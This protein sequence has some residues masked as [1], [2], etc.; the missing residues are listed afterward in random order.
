MVN[1]VD[2]EYG[3]PEL[4]F[5]CYTEAFDNFDPAGGQVPGYLA[6]TGG[7][8]NNAA[9]DSHLSPRKDGYVRSRRPV[10]HASR[11]PRHS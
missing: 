10:R 4:A 1:V 7:G 5:H 9:S 8:V 2:S 3:G 11:P 6:G